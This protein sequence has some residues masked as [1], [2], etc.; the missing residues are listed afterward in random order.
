M[1]PGWLHT[2][3]QSHLNGAYTDVQVAK[4][5]STNT[6]PYYYIWPP[7]TGDNTDG[8]LRTVSISTKPCL[9]VKVWAFSL[10]VALSHFSGFSESFDV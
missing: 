6:P 8:N 5:V 3:L 4:I 10:W 7:W 2:W 9:G 1:S